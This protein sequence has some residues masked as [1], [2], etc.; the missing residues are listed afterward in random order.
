[1]WPI[2]NHDNDALRGYDEDACP[3]QH[4][5]SFLDPP[6]PSPLPPTCPQPWPWT[7]MSPATMTGCC[8]PV[9]AATTATTAAAAT[10]TAAA[11][12]LDSRL[13]CS[14]LLPC[15]PGPDPRVIAPHSLGGSTPRVF[16]LLLLRYRTIHF[17]GDP[18]LSLTCTLAHDSLMSSSSLVRLGLPCKPPHRLGVCHTLAFQT[19]SRLAW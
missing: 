5:R 2:A 12:A 9:L 13:P 18:S 3:I 11:A 17:A 6:T 7:H 4:F 14:G 15:V 16:E 8:C 10:A 1:M 19:W